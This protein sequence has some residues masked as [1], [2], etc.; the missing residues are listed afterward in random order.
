MVKTDSGG[1]SVCLLLMNLT[2]VF[3]LCVAVVYC[4]GLHVFESDVSP[5]VGDAVGVEFDSFAELN[6]QFPRH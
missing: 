6:S 3:V 5:A 1:Q 4:G 2:V